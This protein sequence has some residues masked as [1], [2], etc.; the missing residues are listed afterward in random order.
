[1]LQ[2]DAPIL[3]KAKIP[4]QGDLL[5]DLVLR[6]QVPDIFSKAYISEDGLGNYVLD[7][8]YIITH[9]IVGSSPHII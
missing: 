8:K 6:V 1:V 9:L 5:S 4:R 3:V 7:R 2:M